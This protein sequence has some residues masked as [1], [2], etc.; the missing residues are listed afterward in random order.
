MNAAGRYEVTGDAQSDTASFWVSG[1]ASPWRTFGECA[2]RWL[3]ALKSGEMEQR[4]AVINTVFGELFL[5]KGEA[6]EPSRV[7]ALRGAYLCGEVPA[8]ARVLTAGVDM[9]R[10]RLHYVVRAWGVSSTSW[11]IQHGEL[12]GETDQ[13]QVWNDLAALLEAEY[14]GHRI[15]RMMVD[16]GY[17]PDAAYAFARRFP[18]QVYPSKGH[19]GQADPVSVARIDLNRQGRPER[20]G[21]PLAHVDTSYFKGWVHGR[22]AWPSDQPGAW[23]LPAD[24]SDDYCQQLTAESRIVK[25]NGKVIWVKHGANHYLDCEA[26]AA[27]AAHMLRVHLI[28][29]APS[30]EKPSAPQGTA[31]QPAPP[32]EISAAERQRRAFAMGTGRPS[33]SGGNWTSGWRR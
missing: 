10:D 5:M 12:W 29:G 17:R 13:P 15:H 19:D 7:A 14:G 24:A 31:P 11:L 3:E 6:P 16:S 28:K 1:L 25:P 33:F 9:A 8:E 27:A 22:I 32:P 21:T 2:K 26:L 20:R 18:S 23:H 4:Q 30:T